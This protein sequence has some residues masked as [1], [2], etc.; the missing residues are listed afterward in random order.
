MPELNGGCLISHSFPVQRYSL[1][2]VAGSPFMLTYLRNKPPWIQLLIF[3]GLTAMIAVLTLNTGAIIVARLNGL[4]INQVGSMSAADYARPE[5]VG[6]LKG[7]L[8]TQFFGIFFLPSLVF[9]YLTDPHPL[10]YLGLKAPQKSYFLVISLF[11]ILAAYFTVELFFVINDAMI[12]RLPKS[13]QIWVSGSETSANGMLDNVLSMKNLKDLLITIFLVGA[14]PAIGEEL[15]FRGV[16]QKIFIQIFKRAWPGIIFTGF[17]FSAIHM[18]FEGF[19]ARM[20]LGIILGALYW[21]SGSLLTS[22]LCHCIF[23]SISILLT[24]YKLADPK[25]KETASPAF[26]LIGLFS[27]ILIIFLINYLRKKS[28]V[29]YAT[30][31]PPPEEFTTA[32]QPDQEV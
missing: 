1:K 32:G 26:I 30:E 25:S 22:M 28:S 15:F 3:G 23:N 6:V 29:T 14:L 19:L 12:H 21:Y 2:P 9:S 4:T 20:A 8:I 16:I 17:L 31:F 13:M 5:L 24:Y 18:Q 7:M 11:T 27:L 10:R